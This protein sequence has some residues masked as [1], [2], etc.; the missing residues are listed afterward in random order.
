MPGKLRHAI[1]QGLL[2]GDGSGW[3]LPGTTFVDFGEL[4]LA[5]AATVRKFAI[6]LPLA[7][8]LPKNPDNYPGV[9]AAANAGRV[10]GSGSSQFATLTGAWCVH[11]TGAGAIYN[12]AGTTVQIKVISTVLAT[13]GALT[14]LSAAFSVT[15]GANG[16][17]PI[18]ITA[19]AE[20]QVNANGSGLL[21]TC[22]YLFNGDVV[23]VELVVAGILNFE[24][25]IF[26]VAL[27]WA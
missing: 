9:L 26:G 7:S 8:G 2:G 10:L 1:S 24:S 18:A 21:T 6:G 11:I 17:D 12:P 23:I 20:R 22:A 5:G 16:I 25:N 3:Q 4:N 15:T 19:P 27:E 14:N 13:F